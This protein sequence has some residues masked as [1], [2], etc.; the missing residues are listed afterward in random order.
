MPLYGYKFET[1]SGLKLDPVASANVDPIAIGPD[2][3]SYSWAS[4]IPSLSSSKSQI[5]DTLSLSLSSYPESEASQGLHAGD[6][7]GLV[8]AALVPI[9]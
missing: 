2:A 5:S 7:N 3:Q 1:N 8:T 4:K 9:S 6:N